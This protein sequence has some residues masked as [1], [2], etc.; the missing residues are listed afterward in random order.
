MTEAPAHL[1]RGVPGEYRERMG[2]LNADERLKLFVSNWTALTG[3]AVIVPREEAAAGI[4]EMLA[5][6]RQRGPLER[7]L[8]A[9]TEELR[10]YGVP[11]VL[12]EQGLSGV[13]WT[14]DQD[15]EAELE[16]LG[17]PGPGEAGA[18]AGAK[19]QAR[20]PLLRAAERCQLGIVAP[21]AAI[22][23]TGTL[24]VWSAGR[25]GRSV[26]LLPGMLLAILPAGRIVARMGEA[27]ERVNGKA[28][29]EGGLPASLNLITGPSRSADIENDLTIGV[30]GPGVVGVVIVTSSGT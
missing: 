30:H 25:Q 28:A 3:E 1:Y 19:W 5:R 26:S 29:R 6:F 11:R 24:A 21:A 12:Q 18:L 2:R 9:D 20:S 27:F 16:Q 23:N 10:G 13:P 15:N 8:Y 4:G 14:E 22:A 17:L 7:V